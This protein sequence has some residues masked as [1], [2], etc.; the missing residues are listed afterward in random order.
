MF[1]AL[2][3]SKNKPADELTSTKENIESNKRRPDST[4]YYNR[5]DVEVDGNNDNNGESDKGKIK[6][7]VEVY[8]QSIQGKETEV[9]SYNKHRNDENN[10]CIENNYE[11][12]SKEKSLDRNSEKRYE[13]NN[14]E[15]NVVIDSINEIMNVSSSFSS[16]DR[17]SNHQR[18]KHRRRRRSTDRRRH[19]SRGRSRNRDKDMHRHRH[20]HRHRQRSRDRHR[21]R[22]RKR[23]RD[24]QRS[25]DRKRSRDRHRSRDRQRRTSSNALQRYSTNRGSNRRSNE[26]S[27]RG[28]VLSSSVFQKSEK[29]R[30]S[31]S[32]G[33]NNDA[34]D[35]DEAVNTN[36]NSNSNI[37]S[38]TIA[39]RV[40]GGYNTNNESNE[41]NGPNELNELP[42]LYDFDEDHWKNK[43]MKKDL[44][45]NDHLTYSMLNRNKEFPQ[46]SNDKEKKEDSLSENSDI[47]DLSEGELLKRVM[48]ISEFASTDNKCHNETDIS[49]INR[50]T[51]RK[52]RQYMNRRGGF[53]RPLS[54]AF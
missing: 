40:R 21:S 46:L 33:Q 30:R 48:G 27:N 6:N 14:D 53:N 37:N 39:Q 9:L 52:Y 34:R 2:F 26:E 43:R 49:G 35:R 50:R 20:R 31:I 28:S 44:V 38:N 19:R 12:R 18:S 47:E 36:V 1:N 22:D 4:D 32:F 7:N 23:S 10:D 15:N 17:S 41:T 51:K 29:R 5:S 13:M 42:E 25:R 54:P 11:Q 8:E 45:Q 3:K 16:I 24:R